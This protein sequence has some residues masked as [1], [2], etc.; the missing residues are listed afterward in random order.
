MH[1]DLLLLY[2]DYKL[3][4]SMFPDFMATLKSFHFIKYIYLKMIFICLSMREMPLGI[5]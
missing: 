4:L 2:I 1:N 3:I 5:T